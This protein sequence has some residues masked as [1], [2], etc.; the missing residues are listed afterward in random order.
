[1][2]HL[3]TL[4]ECAKEAGIQN[5]YVHGIL[6]GVDTAN[7]RYN[8]II[9]LQLLEVWN[10]FVILRTGWKNS[11]MVELPLSRDRMIS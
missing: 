10:W 5:V 4:L 3:Y 9:Y 8:N 7:G 1:M 6:D 2:K 11:S